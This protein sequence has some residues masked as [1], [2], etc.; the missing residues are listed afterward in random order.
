MIKKYVYYNR[1]FYD[2]VKTKEREFFR[3]EHPKLEKTWATTKS[4]KVSILEKLAQAN[5][6]VDDLEDDIYPEKCEPTLPK[7]VSLIITRD[8][9]HLVYEKR[10][11]NGKRLN[12]KMVLPENY[13]LQDQIAILNE[14]IKEKYEGESIL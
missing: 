1:E 12:I 9:P 5:K 7:Y 3:V 8:K 4:E 6:V 10:I 2:K 14:K 11:V 13:D